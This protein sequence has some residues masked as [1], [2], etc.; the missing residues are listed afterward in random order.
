M[1]KSFISLA[2]IILCGILL[3]GAAQIAS[4]AD[5]PVTIISRIYASPGREAEVEARLHKLVAFVLKA[6]P[7][8]TYRLLRSKEDQTVFLLYEIYPSQAAAEEHFAVTLPGLGN[9]LGPLP[10]GL[11]ARPF[12]FEMFRALTD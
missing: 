6:E 2:R 3:V 9:A 7:N 12:E 5:E 10:E 11:S 1:R 4:A 8:I